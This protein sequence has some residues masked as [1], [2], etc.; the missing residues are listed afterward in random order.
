L[1]LPA[2]ASRLAGSHFRLVLISQLIDNQSLLTPTH[3]NLRFNRK[4]ACQLYKGMQISRSANYQYLE[5]K[6]PDAKELQLEEVVVEVFQEYRWRYSERRI[7][8]EMK[9]RGFL[10]R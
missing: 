10:G 5:V 6:D 4:S 2:R 8:G 9:E 1:A 3:V 7:Y